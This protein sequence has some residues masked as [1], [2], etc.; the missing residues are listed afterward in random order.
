MDIHL[1]EY[2]IPPSESHFGLLSG[3]SGALAFPF[4]SSSSLL[5]RRFF[6]DSIAP[7]IRENG[8]GS[9]SDEPTIDPRGL[10]IGRAPALLG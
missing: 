9:A 4:R 10:E 2:T 3:S 5:G 6:P 1:M 7:R 8:N